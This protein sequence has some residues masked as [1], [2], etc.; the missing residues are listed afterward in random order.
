MPKGKVALPKMESTASFNKMAK[1]LFRHLHEP[2]ALSRNPLVRRFF[3][4]PA[5]G[6]FGHGRE[7]D[8][9]DRIHQL[10][11]KGADQ[12]RDSD[13]VLGR[14]ERARRQHAIVTSH[15]LEQ[16]PIREVAAALGI[17]YQYCYR[18][19]ADICR[20]LARYIQ[21]YD[22]APALD[23]FPEVDEY[24]FLID[25]ASRTAF[26][27]RSTA[28][29]ECDRV[30]HVA[31]STHQKIEALRTSA[32]VSIEF[33]DIERAEYAYATARA[34]ST[35]HLAEAAPPLC[36]LAQASVDL[37]GSKL[38]YSCANV[39]EAM[40]MAQRAV[41]RL[42]VVQAAASTHVKELYVE[43]LYDLAKTS[44]SLGDADRGYDCMA[45][46]EANL[47]YVRAASSRL[48][49][50]IVVAIWRLR[51]QMLLNS[52]SWYP[53]AQRLKGLAAAFEQA[54]ASGCLVEAAGALTGLSEYH[55]F[56][57]ND[58][59]ALRSA[60]LAIFLVNQQS[61]ERVRVQT[62]LSIGLL[63]LATR[64]WQYALSLI[65]GAHQL[66]FCDAYYRQL[67]T[68]FA[69]EHAF[70]LH[71][72]DMALKLTKG[73]DVQGEYA[74]LTVSRKLIAAGS[75][76]ELEQRRE[77][78]VLIDEVLPA[79]EKLGLA[80]VLRDAYSIAARVTGAPRFGRLARDVARLL[81][82]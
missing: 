20:R 75:A 68:Y 58:A 44:Y 29:R 7:R 17:S 48:H 72:F 71:R 14:R 25:R 10:V 82:A 57:G 55:V 50:R 13:F 15:C 67:A 16:R 52:K 33:G 30:I 64:H 8:V 59:E 53:S 60:R 51:N 74:D 76:H 79:A 62:A 65:P 11:R 61:S 63:L 81:T 31:P 80:P 2:R 39:A 27:D 28:F 73:E 37:I 46:A 26:V 42:E 56:A 41:S 5:I 45:N 47:C 38:A 43:S 6:G 35:E 77:A 54:Y 9:L 19:R 23:Y 36:E 24:Q 40:R 49:A 78:R 3:E 21:E 32:L 66:D 34:L 1:H 4:G 22:D 12:C 18:E 70:R 69:A